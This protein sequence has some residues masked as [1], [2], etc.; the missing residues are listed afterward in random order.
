[1]NASTR[2][3]IV[4]ALLALPL[5]LAFC[6]EA[7]AQLQ[8]TTVTAT[9]YDG[10]GAL[11]AGAK[12]T[13]HKVVKNGAVISSTAVTTSASNASGVITFVVPRASTVHLSGPVVGLETAKYPTGRALA[14]PD[15]ATA[16]LA[17]LIPASTSSATGVATQS[18]LSAHA[19]LVAAD[20]TLGHVKGGGNITIAADG[21]MS[22][23]P[24]VT[25]HGA[26]TGLSD[27]DHPQYQLRSEENAANGYLGLD[28][29]AMAPDNRIPASIA[30]DSEITS[31]IGALSSVYAPIVHTH[32]VSQV[33][34]FNF[35]AVVAALGFTPRDA[36]SATVNSFN[37]RSGAVTLTGADVTGALT[38]TPANK[39]GETFTG[40][41]TVTQL[42]IGDAPI[43][44]SSGQPFGFGAS[45][46][47]TSADF[48]GSGLRLGE[49]LANARY[50]VDAGTKGHVFY[51]DSGYSAELMRITSA[52]GVGVNKAIPGA[53]FHVAAK[54]A[55]TKGLIVQMGASPAV[56]SYPVQVLTSVSGE[57]FGV[58]TDG[59]VRVGGVKVLGAQCSA[60]ANATDAATAITQLNL[61]LACL[62]SHG[63]LAP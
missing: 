16:S 39:T 35:A 41:V 15:A 44:K 53:Q 21:T 7:R 47:K 40:P 63:L 33:T 46:V 5:A 37:T 8:M 54:D 43:T 3:R 52:G 36:A 25:D 57:V 14:V 17:D 27:D 42:T 10:A 19:G 45:D 24:G 13:V 22:A 30:R 11:V 9:V 4:H 61:L 32:T 60:I 49:N 20:D 48:R 55:S 28:A 59:S 31:A 2:T 56:G 26:L 23:P 18:A 6:A 12:I 34:D 1:M 38:Y 58:N 62:R 51:A 29:G 50:G